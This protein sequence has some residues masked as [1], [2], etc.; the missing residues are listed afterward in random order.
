MPT[1]WS[2]VL[3]V[4]M[5]SSGGHQLPKKLLLSGGPRLPLNRT[6]QLSLSDR[7]DCSSRDWQRFKS[8]GGNKLLLSVGH[9]LL[10]SGG[11]QLLL[12][13]GQGFLFSGAS[14]RSIPGQK[15]GG[16]RPAEYSIWQGRSIAIS[17]AVSF[18]LRQLGGSFHNVEGG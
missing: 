3:V 15:M 16:G 14:S 5:L 10:L 8:S 7:H 17:Y 6:H 18:A 4:Q 9:Q 11:H 2:P 12:N 1:L 13:G